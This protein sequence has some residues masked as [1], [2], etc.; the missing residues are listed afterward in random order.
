M[1]ELLVWQVGNR[2]PSITETVTVDG[3]PFDLTGS[4]VKFKMREVG[5]SVLV[6]D[7]AAVIV[8]AAA[9]TVRYDWAAV[10]VDTAG[11]YLVWW[12]VTTSG[13]TQD[14]GEAVIEIRA[15]APITKTYVELEELKSTLSLQGESYA[16]ADLT[17]ALMA[18]SR[19][20]DGH[21][22]T[23]FYKS[24]DTR[25]YTADQG[26]NWI[27]IDDLVNL[28]TIATPTTTI[29][30]DT[31]GDGTYETTWTNGTDFYLEPTNATADGR[32]FSELVIRSQSGR[33]FPTYQRAI[34]IIGVF[35]WPSVPAL[36]SSATSILA[37]RWLRR[38]REAPFGI[39]AT[40]IET[41]AVIRL[42]RTD[43]DVAFM[44][45]NIKGLTPKLL[46]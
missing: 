35:G 6:V 8:S 24:E 16:D 41:G 28:G 36:V 46:A 43:P 18:A 42:S 34:K 30:V 7:T 27:E 1:P 10:D 23:W 3:V 26:R 9:G 5:S 4:T 40:G 14:V 25:Y 20:I 17:Q 39:I 11:Y 22:N 45:D 31:N 13:K 2:L 37:H 21:K 29:T 38:R 12:E 19:A 32:P 44:L 33:A 15:H